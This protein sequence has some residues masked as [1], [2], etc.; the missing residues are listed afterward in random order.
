MKQLLCFLDTISTSLSSSTRVDVLYLDIKKAFDSVPH[1][2]LLLK[3]WNA[4]I[5]DQLWRFFAAYFTDRTQY[6]TINGVSSSSITVTS[7]VPQGSI[8]GPLLF[9]VYM[10]INDITAVPSSLLPFLYADDGEFLL[11]INSASDFSLFQDD[12]DGLSEWSASSSLNFNISKS[13]IMSFTSS[14][15]LPPVKFSYKLDHN[16]LSHVTSCKDLGVIFSSDHSWSSHYS[17]VSSKAYSVLSL[18]R[19]TFNCNLLTGCKHKL[20]VTLILPHLT[21]CSPVWRPSLIK[22]IVLLEKIQHRATKYILNHTS[23]TYKD[24]LKSLKLLPLMYQFELNDILLYISCLKDSNSSLLILNE[25]SF[26]SAQTRSSTFSKL[27]HKPV[28]SSV[29]SISFV[30]RFPRLTSS[31]LP[32]IKQKL[33]THFWTHFDSHFDPSTPCTFHYCCPCSRCSS[34]SRLNFCP[35]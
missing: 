28:N 21:Y 32:S 20:Y 22:D 15:K 18:I 11:N 25:L 3:L 33:I 23:A 1:N 19:R 17:K 8:L 34:Q 10:Y 5:T 29:H 7:G 13:F 12:L 35:I 26:S 4:G 6:V 9:L 24:R 30:S 14:S 2:E 27:P 16:C 31:P